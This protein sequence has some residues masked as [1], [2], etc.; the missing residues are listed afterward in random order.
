MPALTPDQ[1]HRQDHPVDGLDA[2]NVVRTR[3]SLRHWHLAEDELVYVLEGELTL[4]EDGIETVL[5]PGDAATFAAGVPIGHCLANRG[6]RPARCLVVGTRAA[7]DTVTY[8]D[9]DRVL[10]RDRPRG[11]RRWTDAAGRP[12]DDPYATW[13]GRD[14]P[15]A[16]A[17]G[18]DG[19]A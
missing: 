4:L 13:S 5:R 7:V 14:D 17:R 18:D 12:V 2:Q 8:P 19:P 10:H 11:E 9:D 3:S 6:P 16:G 15:D 1:F